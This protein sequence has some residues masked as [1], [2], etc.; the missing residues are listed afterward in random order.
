MRNVLSGVHPAGALATS[1]AAFISV[2]VFHTASGP[3][4]GWNTWPSH[5]TTPS[6]FG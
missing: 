6:V 2:A 3:S 5:C 1:P 4:E